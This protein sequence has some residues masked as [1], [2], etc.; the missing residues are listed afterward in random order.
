LYTP[1]CLGY[2][3]NEKSKCSRTEAFEEAKNSVEDLIEACHAI[4]RKLSLKGYRT[5]VIDKMTTL[6]LLVPEIMEDWQES[7]ACR[8]A[9]TVLA[10]CKAHFPAMDFATIARGVPKGTNVKKALAEIEGFDTLFAQR[11][12]HSAW[13]KKHAPPPG[14]SYD[15][16]DEEGSGSSAH[17]SDDGSGEGSGKDDTYQA[18]EDDPESSE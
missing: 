11:V 7:S 12:N 16:D 14:F 1:A 10:M 15:E 9:S 4:A 18:S 3:W 8:A 2:E 5:T 6:M 17:R 13:Y